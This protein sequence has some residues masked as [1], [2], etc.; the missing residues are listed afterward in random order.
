MHNAAITQCTELP[1]VRELLSR[2][3]QLSEVTVGALQALDRGEVD[4]V[5]AFVERR[6]QILALA[7][8]LL[9][10]VKLLRQR[11]GAVTE[12]DLGAA[13]AAVAR[14]GREVHTQSQH[15]IAGVSARKSAISAELKQMGSADAAH[16]AY[17]QA[18]PSRGAR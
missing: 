7:A 14:A 15:L 11:S 13:L 9:Q 1:A 10:E 4:E 17:A 16:A 2:F 6:E 3:A 12:P 5:A 8:P 18:A